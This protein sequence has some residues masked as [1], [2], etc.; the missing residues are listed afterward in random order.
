M[1]VLAG[2]DD[3]MYSGERLLVGWEALSLR[4]LIVLGERLSEL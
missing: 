2:I 1:R 4:G 3:V